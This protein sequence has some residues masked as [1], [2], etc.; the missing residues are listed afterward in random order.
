MASLLILPIASI[1]Y[2]DSLEN[3][4]KQYKTENH[5]HKFDLIVICV[6]A[7]LLL[8]TGSGLYFSAHWW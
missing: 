6:L 4:I 1:F 2:T 7:W 3:F 5:L 8:A